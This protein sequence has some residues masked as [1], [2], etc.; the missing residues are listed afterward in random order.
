MIKKIIEL[1][2]QLFVTTQYDFR[3]EQIYYEKNQLN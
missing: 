1:L 3:M 2:N